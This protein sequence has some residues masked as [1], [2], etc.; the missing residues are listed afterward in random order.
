MRRVTNRAALTDS[1]VLENIRPALR[2]VTTET[3]LVLRK[4]RGA[5]ADIHRAFVRGMTIDAAHSAF[6]HRVMTWQVILAPHVG[7]AGEAN[8]LP[9]PGRI[10]G[11]PSWV[12]RG[13][14]PPCRKTVR[15]FYFT[16]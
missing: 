13:L 11:Q 14:G 15:R 6:G 8:R 3:T 1:F 7:V 12:A 5:A 10:H 16:S 2:L 9:G 4:Q